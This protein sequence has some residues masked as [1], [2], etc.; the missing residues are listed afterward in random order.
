MRNQRK[1]LINQ[2]DQRLK[3]L[4]E[5]GKNPLPSGGW[6]HHLRK[7]LNM[8]LEQLGNRLNIT[9]QGAKSL[10]ERE[11]KGSISV[12][13]LKEVGSALE[14]EFVYGFVPNHDSV[15]N[16]VDL[17]ARNL[18]QKIVLRTNQN[19]QLE[20]QGNS[21]DRLNKAIDELADEIKREMRRSLWD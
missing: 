2:L 16:L 21:Q 13:S 18:A 4:I 3:P 14:M 1:L 6:I 7:A 19:M 8:T 12:N 9:K 10:E 17:R 5:F 20:N 11:A 15:E